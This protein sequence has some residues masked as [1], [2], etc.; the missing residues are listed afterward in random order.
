MKR[1]IH[2]LVVLFATLIAY[3]FFVENY[4]EIMPVNYIWNGVLGML[5]FPFIFGAIAC[6]L[7]RGI[8]IVRAILVSLIPIVA[9]SPML[10]AGSDPAKPGLEYY[11][12]MV[13]IVSFCVGA[14]AEIGS[15]YLFKYVKQKNTPNKSLNPDAQN[16]RAG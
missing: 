13:F 14:F 2:N 8:S 3:Y 12:Y 5:A 11:I 16:A 7:F 4:S 10:M 1:I 9:L 15:Y 6:Y